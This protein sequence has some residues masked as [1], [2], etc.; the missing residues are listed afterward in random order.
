MGLPVTAVIGLAEAVRA[1][2]RPGVSVYLG[3]FGAQL[4]SV[5]HEMIRQ[6]VSD[7]DILMASGG[8]LLDQL[9]G[10]GV[11]RS[12]TFAHCWSPVGP[13]PAWNF[14]RAAESGDVGIELHEVTLG[15]FN[16][17]L[18]AGAHG[19]PFMPVRDLPGTGY[20]E[21]GWTAGMLSTA[22]CVFGCTPVVR[23]LS[24]DVAFVHVD[25]AD[26]DGNAHIRGPL[27]EVQIAAQAAATVVLVAEELAS[28]P[29]VRAAGVSIPGVLVGAVVHQPGA[30]APDGA[31][32]RY[33]RDTEAYQ[34]YSERSR[35][36]QG[37]HSWLAEVRA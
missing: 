12:A 3:N 19:V 11:P 29:A 23:A 21:D 32:G 6:R 15:L 1:H 4:F 36:P 27:G 17:A 25:M 31:I 8:L 26:E 10:A 13:T 33:E 2:V 18:L 14:R 20:T 22:D 28:G 16:A 24:P 5:G 34:R 35:S 7:V 9:I 37:F 30:L